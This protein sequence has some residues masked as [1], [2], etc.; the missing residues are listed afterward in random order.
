MTSDPPLLL[1]YCQINP[2]LVASLPLKFSKI[3]IGASGF[4]K[5]YAVP[6]VGDVAESP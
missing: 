1:P 5:I 6:P 4:V 2:I 3:F